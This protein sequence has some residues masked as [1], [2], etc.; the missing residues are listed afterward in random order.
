MYMEVNIKS[1]EKKLD[2][3]Y[4]FKSARNLLEQYGELEKQIIHFSPR[5]DLNDP[6]EGHMSLYWKGDRIAW[7]GLF[8]NYINCLEHSFSMYR[9]GARKEQLHEMSIFFDY[10]T[11]PSKEYQNLINEITTEFIKLPFIER[12]ITILGDKGI[13]VSK[14]ELKFFLYTIHIEGLNIIM[15]HHSIYG[16]MENKEIIHLNNYRLNSE[17]FKKFIDD[18]MKIRNNEKEN[19]KELF[20]VWNDMNEEMQ[21]HEKVLV[22]VIDEKQ[23]VDRYYLL[24]EFPGAYLQQIEKLIHPSCYMA[25]FSKD[26]SNTSM[27]GN[28]AD[29]HK[30]ICMIFKLNKYDNNYYTPIEQTYSY[31][32]NSITKKFI[33][34]KLEKVIYGGEYLNINFFEMLGRLNKIQLEYWFKDGEQES[35]II[36]DIMD[37]KDNWRKTYWRYFNNRYNTKTK[38]WDFEKEYRLCIEDTFEDY[39]SNESRNL[40]YPFDS[41]EGIIFGI[42]TTHEDKVKILSILSEKCVINKKKD[43]KIYQAYFDEDTKTIKLNELKSIEKNVID[44]KYIKN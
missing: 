7:K 41:L 21:L 16:L 27:W 3:L 19:S 33:N 4:R 13:M 35:Y 43:F 30:G 32:S 39:S 15:K 10:S 9:L 31:S 40:K 36:K 1:T 14:N 20:K 23:K 44:G 22:D 8:K 26:F 24:S 25:C 37:D 11:L 12:I 17:N 28:Y 29:K 2:Y 38:E 5:E 6:L 18:Y 34:A 42:E